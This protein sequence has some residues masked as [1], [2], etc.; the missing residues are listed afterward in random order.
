VARAADA[1]GQRLALD[2]AHGRVGGLALQIGVEHAADPRVVEAV[3]HLG[4]APEA[5]QP[6]PGTAL[7]SEVRTV[8]ATVRSMRLSCARNAVP[9]PPRPSRRIRH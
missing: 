1:V 5:P 8:R 6:G 4:L 9:W 7:K 3:D 2:E